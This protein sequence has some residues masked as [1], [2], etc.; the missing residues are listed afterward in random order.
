MKDTIDFRRR[1]FLIRCCQGASTALIP[2]RLRSLAFSPIVNSLDTANADIDFHLHPHYRAQMPLDAMLLKTQAG[3]DKFVTE[4]YHDQIA[5]MFAEWSSSLLQSPQ[6]MRPI[7]KAVTPD[8][9]ASSLR[10][11]E[12]RPVR[13]GS[14]LEIHQNRFAHAATLGRDAFLEELRS[15]TN[16]FSKIMTADFRVVSIDALPATSSSAVN[17]KGGKE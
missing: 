15:T 12:S 9:A 16:S 6:D 13:S 14:A 3:L 11:V 8:F 17:L 5:A 10:P 1:K 7:E 2:A 4:K